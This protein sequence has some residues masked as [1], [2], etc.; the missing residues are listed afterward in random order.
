M[1]KPANNQ[2]EDDEFARADSDDSDTYDALSP[3]N[4]VPMISPV[5]PLEDKI[6][7]NLAGSNDLPIIETVDDSHLVKPTRAEK[8]SS[9]RYKHPTL[10]RKISSMEVSDSNHLQLPKA[11]AASY[12][13][14]N[15]MILESIEESPNSRPNRRNI[16][17]SKDL[18]FEMLANTSPTNGMEVDQ[19]EDDDE[20][21]L[22]TT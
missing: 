3:Q 2:D 12:I 8:A 19:D 16:E 11:K 9:G 18:N 6:D 13:I 5:E 7:L 22:P 15:Q 17:E 1:S 14:P 20:D 4:E 21:G 10:F